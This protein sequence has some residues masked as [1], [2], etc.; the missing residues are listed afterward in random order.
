ML[1]FDRRVEERSGSAASPITDA[2]R[3]FIALTCI[4]SHSIGNARPGR[5][6][7]THRNATASRK[8]NMN[9]TVTSF[10]HSPRPLL[11]L[12][13]RL[14]AIV[15]VGTLVTLAWVGAEQSSHQAVTTAVQ[16]FTPVARATHVTLPPVEIV[17]HREQSTAKPVRRAT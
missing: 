17:W 4:P 12:G 11:S 10:G 9:T 6:Q 5:L 13:T 2:F 7:S 1:S 3:H 16:T 14:A 15:A 8:N